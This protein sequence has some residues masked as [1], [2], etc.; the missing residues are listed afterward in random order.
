MKNGTT[1]KHGWGKA[2]AVLLACMLALSC[3][4]CGDGGA[5]A[6]P[7]PSPSASPSPTPAVEMIQ[8]ATVSEI[9]GSLNIRSADSTDSQV[10][11]QAYPGDHFEVLTENYSEGWHEISYNGGK[12]YVS[13]EYVTV[14][15][16]D[17]SVLS[18]TPA[19]NQNDSAASPTPNATPNAETPIIV[20]GSGRSDLQSS[21]AQSDG[22]TTQT[23][24]DT[25]DPERR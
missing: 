16:M 24:R 7:S 13:A 18:A 14:S 17:A 5:E 12:A 4:A 1:G 20:N 23:I 3:A 19:P 6:S 8:V 11:S 25:E 21:D 22:M 2:P 10:L 9:E 15:E